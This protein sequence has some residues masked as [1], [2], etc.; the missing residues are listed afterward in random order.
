MHTPAAGSPE[1]QAVCDAARPYVIKKYAL[2]SKLPQ[3]ILFKVRRI[4]VLGNY[5]SFEAIPIFKDGSYV[6][7]EYM[8]DIV[9]ELCLKREHERWHVIYDLSSTDVPSDSEMRQ[10]WSVFPKDFPVELIPQF[11]REQFDRVK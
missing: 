5:C 10:I 4:Q 1:R 7:T 9:F 3:P 2:S 11:W 6:S 8:M